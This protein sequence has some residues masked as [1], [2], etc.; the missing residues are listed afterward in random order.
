[1]NK[2]IKT[3]AL[4]GV[5][6][7]MFGQSASAATTDLPSREELWQIIQSQQSQINTL[8]NR[9][10]G[11]EE[12]AKNAE[13][14]AVENEEAIKNN[15][16]T[17]ETSS[18]GGVAPGWWNDTSIGG[19]GEIHM[20]KGSSKDEVDFHRFVLFINH[21]FSDD[22]RL[23]SEIEVEHADEIFLEQAYLEFDLNDYNTAK[24]GG[25]L[26]P[27]GIMNE[28]H[29][30][31]TFFGVERNPI[32][33]QIIPTTWR[34][35]G[36]SF[37]GDLGDGF[38]YDVALHS[39]L[40]SNNKTPGTYKPRDGR[41]KLSK[42]AAEDGAATARLKYKRP[43]V[44][45]AAAIN[46]QQDMSQG[47]DAEKADATLLQAHTILTHDGLALRALYAQWD[48][49]GSNAAALGRDEQYGFYVEPS[50][51]FDLPDNIPGEKAGIFARY[52][53]YD[54]EA[55]DNTDSQVEQIDVGFNFWPH[56]D[57]VLKA[58]MA[59]IGYE[60]AALEDDAIFN[61]GAGFQF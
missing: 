38:S 18:G 57:V 59:F 2:L 21:E 58:D 40:D 42:A 61:L 25:F 56:E 19:Y 54:N 36:V 7:L 32:E 23:V 48:V 24:V 50:Y 4:A 51:T 1:M 37:S 52:N 22:I 55:G 10:E 29:E 49:N 27:V 31:T 17:L 53:M 8:N 47:V 44:E 28:H 15:V 3:T 45:L 5:A 39:G 60:A 14:K 20:N 30:P 26:V 35:A 9:I 34:E 33:T 16:A 11:T 46:Y 13:V 41:D 12:V 6:A 43:G